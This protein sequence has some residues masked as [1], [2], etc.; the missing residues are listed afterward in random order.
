[1]ANEKYLR[2]IT[3]EH[4]TKPLYM[5]YVAAFL[6]MLNAA[7]NCLLSF[8]EIF[9]AFKELPDTVD[10]SN[11]EPG[12]KLST[13]EDQLDKLGSLLGLSRALPVVD[14]DIPTL[15]DNETFQKII[16][17]KILADHWDGT[18]NGL[19]QIMEII[20]PDLSYEVIDNQD[21]SYTISILNPAATD[22]EIAL[23]FNGFILPKPSGVLVNYI[24]FDTALFGWDSDTQF[25]KGWDEG[26]WN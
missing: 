25:I 13:V 26:Q 3:S 6:D 24:I 23:L 16:R 21:M 14:P 9:N 8:N 5:A 15:L 10:T 7:E 4:A 2:L 19:R 11:P 18:N 17:S 20:F 1:M 22:Q 12:S